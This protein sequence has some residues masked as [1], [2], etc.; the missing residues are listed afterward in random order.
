[1]IAIPYATTGI[2]ENNPIHLD[3]LHAASKVNLRFI[4]NVALDSDK[5]IIAAFA[6]DL[7]K[8][9]DKGVC[10]VKKLSE[11]SCVNGD[12][13]VTSNGGY[14]LDQNMYQS[15]KSVSTAERFAGENGVIIVCCACTDGIGDTCFEEQM[16]MGSA[17]EIDAYLSKIPPKKTIP[18]QWCTQVY[19]RI[20]KKHP[21]IL[22][23][24]YLDHE[25][26]RKANLIPASTPDEALELA[27]EIMGKNAEVIVIPDGV[28]VVAR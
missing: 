22:V 27:F 9:H 19:A 12:I 5:K 17:E 24:T 25:K 10:F 6:G 16:T 3:M 2:I 4:C 20:L 18:E 14:P 1:M 26:I 7:E 11:C 15:T 13:V 8:A 28:S 21:V 23:S